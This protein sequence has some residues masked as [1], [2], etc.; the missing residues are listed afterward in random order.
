LDF[1]HI[2]EFPWIIYLRYIANDEKPLLFQITDDLNNLTSREL[3]L[4]F[5]IIIADD[6]LDWEKLYLHEKQNN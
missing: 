3:G 6:D 2:K 5:P 4:L 1:C